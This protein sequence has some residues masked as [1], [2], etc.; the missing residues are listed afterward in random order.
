[1]LSFK[2]QE[3]TLFRNNVAEQVWMD[4]NYGP[5]V[6]ESGAPAG[7][8]AIV[9]ETTGKVTAER[10][11]EQERAAVLEANKRL[12]IESAF[13]RELFAQAPSFIAILTGPDHVFA[14][15][16]HAYQRLVGERHVQG[17][18]V[19]EA[20]P[21]LA[22]QGFFEILDG[23]RA[24]GEPFVGQGARVSLLRDDGEMEDRFLDFVYQPITDPAGQVTGIFVE[25]QDVTG[26]VRGE[27]HLRLVVNELNHRVKNTLA[28]VQAVAAQTFRNAR[29]LP[30]AQAS[31]SARIMALAKANDL[32][33][34]QNWEGASLADVMAVAAQTHAGA[35]PG[36][37]VC[38]GPVV[39]LSPKTALALSMAMHELAT[40]AVKYGAL[41]APGGRVVVRWSAGGEVARLRLEWREEGGP[42]VA[43]P[44]RRGF[45][46]RLIERG[47]AAELGGEVEVRFE[48]AGVVC[49]IDAPLDLHEADRS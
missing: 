4:L 42:T 14:L 17:L 16:N 11:L 28:M 34:G 33:T 39:R 43:P 10:A 21:E 18:P 20:L 12:S 2:D 49:L 24:T 22:G 26:R 8:L 32:L 6:D 48:P 36:R 41:S 30:Q 5:V 3:L 13:L 9:V 37:F 47:L 40:N 19:R 35:E 45:G 7:V 1:V 27:Q 23:V 25:G 44:A 29:D 15:A 31:F 38:E 46:S